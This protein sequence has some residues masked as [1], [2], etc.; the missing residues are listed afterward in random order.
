M[1]KEINMK[2]EIVFRFFKKKREEE[3][4]SK[5]RKM[6]IKKGYAPLNNITCNYSFDCKK[7]KRSN[8]SPRTQKY[9]YLITLK[10]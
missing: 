7:T 9:P 8:K 10:Y 3:M 4:Y 6:L 2:N 5:I 1:K